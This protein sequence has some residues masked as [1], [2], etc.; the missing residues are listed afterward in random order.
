MI[1]DHAA[2]AGSMKTYL[3]LMGYTVEVA[4]TLAAARK[5]VRTAEFDLLVCDIHLPDGTGWDLLES[6]KEKEPIRAIAFSAYDEPDYRAK[7]EAAGFLDYIVKGS[8]PEVLIDAIER[9]A[10]DV[11]AL[12][13]PVAA[14]AF[15]PRHAQRSGRAT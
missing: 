4:A 11:A 3:D 2:T 14:P 8:P 10:G 15:S 7:S 13:E 5:L 12:D 1:E 6:L 9:A